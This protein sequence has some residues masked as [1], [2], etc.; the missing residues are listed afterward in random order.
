VQLADTDIWVVRAG[1]NG[2]YSDHF[3]D[4]G[5]VAIGWG[6]VGTIDRFDSD[7]AIRIRLDAAFPDTK[8]GARPVIV[9]MLKRFVR[10][11]QIGDPVATYDPAQRLYHLGSVQS[12]AELMTRKTHD[13]EARI[14][15]VRKVQWL[16]QVPRDSLTVATRNS[17]GSLTTIFRISEEGSQEIR[18]LSLSRLGTAP[19]ESDD[20]VAAPDDTDLVDIF[21]EYVEKSGEF[22]EDQIS[23]LDWQE[24]QELIA[25]ILRAM[26]YRTRVS[27]VGSDRGVDVFASPDGLGLAEPRIFVE[28][29][30]RSGAIGSGDVRSFLGGRHSGDRCLY[31]STGGFS[32]EARYEAERSQI[33][34]TLID[35]PALRTLLIDHYESLDTE[36]RSLV[37]LRKIYWP[38]PD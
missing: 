6:E 19:D 38:I 36:T 32:R 22:V 15:F 1:R 12:D 24:M 37:P 13:Q 16:S 3:L 9:G 27:P 17:L 18:R 2:V 20:Q 8:V 4:A 29:K 5:I 14:E 34:L 23:K 28:V 7:D 35:M 26:G 25:G 33:P 11:I 31:V 21:Q 10:E 30:H